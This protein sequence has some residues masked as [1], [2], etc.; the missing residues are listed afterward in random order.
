MPELTGH[1]LQFQAQ[2]EGCLPSANVRVALPSPRKPD[3][4]YGE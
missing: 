4:Y 1:L 2:L 3:A